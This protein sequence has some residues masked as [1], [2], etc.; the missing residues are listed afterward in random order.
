MKPNA[1]SL[2]AATAAL[3]SLQL[4]TGC[5]SRSYQVR[6]NAIAHSSPA[7]AATSY[8]IRNKNPAV[9]DRSL[10]YQEATRHIKT[11]LSAQ[12]MYEAPTSQMAD[13]IVEL[14]YGIE[15]PRVKYNV[16]QV[17]VFGRKA[18]EGGTNLAE[19]LDSSTKELVGY[20]PESFPVVVREKRLSVCARANRA[21]TEGRPA[22]EYW[23]VDVAI[24][25][26]SHDLRGYLPILASAAMDHIG[27]NTD[28]EATTVLNSEDDAVQFVNRGM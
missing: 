5:A 20:Q 16:Y 10:R 17:P 21:P 11:A 18:A 6:V 24:E 23:R 8:R 7:A 15:A 1:L 2:I 9:D 28:G 12:G 4:C 27:R 22:E 19:S 26:K 25:D 3:A 14:D 13:M